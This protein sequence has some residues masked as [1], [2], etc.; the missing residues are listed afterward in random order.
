MKIAAMIARI[1]LGLV[2]AF[3]GS[4]VFFHFMPMQP[5]PGPAGQFL[6]AMYV[7]HYLI[8]VGLFQLIPGLML[9]ANQYT[10]LALALLAPMIAN[11]VFF[12]IFM[13]PSGLPIAIVVAILWGI[14]ALGVRSAFAGLLARKAL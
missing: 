4:N 5:M 14:A 9:L 1:L 8:V 3:F 2:F 13:A 11:I 10:P 12:H 7:S 6:G